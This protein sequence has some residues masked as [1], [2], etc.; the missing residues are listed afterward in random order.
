MNLTPNDNVEN[1]NYPERVNSINQ[2]HINNSFFKRIL[3]NNFIFYGLMCLLS[4]F[5]LVFSRDLVK[6]SFIFQENQKYRVL[7]Q[8][9]DNNKNKILRQ[10]KFANNIFDENSTDYNVLISFSNF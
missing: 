9:E 2:S 6:K 7:P 3:K 1:S 5:F 4:L 10:L 8:E